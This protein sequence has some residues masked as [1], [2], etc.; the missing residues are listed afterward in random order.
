MI[1]VV[2]ASAETILREQA[3]AFLGVAGVEVAHARQLC[4]LA[5]EGPSMLLVVSR[6][7]ARTMKRVA[8]LVTEA[9]VCDRDYTTRSATALALRREIIAVKAI[10][11][12]VLR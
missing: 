4:E 5:I 3:G 8:D 7:Y 9:E 6:E 11:S 1:E 2:D 10:A 12:G